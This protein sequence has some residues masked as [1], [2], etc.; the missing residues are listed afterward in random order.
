[1]VF[2]RTKTIDNAGVMYYENIYKCNRCNDEI[3]DDHPHYEDFENDIHLCWGCGFIE[4]KIPEEKYLQ[5]C[6]VG[7]SNMH[8]GVNP[9]GE[10][11]IWTGI[12][13]PPWE[14]SNKRQRNSPQYANWRTKVFERDKYTCQK[15]GQIGGEL[16]AH[17][18]KPFAEFKK[19]RYEVSNGLT[20]CV[21][22]HREIHRKKR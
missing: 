22:C 13:T 14:R 3:I 1:M 9:K 11:E 5:H 15:C 10:I 16:N 18:I 21:E 6:G 12:K 8:A 7:L 17:H 2:L 4:G 20:V 19:H